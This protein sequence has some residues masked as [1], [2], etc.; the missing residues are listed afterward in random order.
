MSGIIRRWRQRPAPVSVG[1]PPNSPGP[2]D[3]RFADRED[4]IERL[5][6]HETSR[7]LLE[8]LAEK[9]QKKIEDMIGDFSDGIEGNL[10][11]D[12]INRFNVNREVTLG[13]FG[14]K[15]LRDSG[16]QLSAL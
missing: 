14:I 4:I 2:V 3:G 5:L 6:L 10:V 8:L 9:F 1:R 7:L 12:I 11:K 13:N 16:T 15:L